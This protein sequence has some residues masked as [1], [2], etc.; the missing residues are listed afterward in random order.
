MSQITVTLYP[1]SLCRFRVVLIQ[2]GYERY[3]SIPLNCDSNT[4]LCITDRLRLERSNTGDFDA[5]A[6][7]AEK[8]LRDGITWNH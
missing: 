6:M 8:I 5:V 3:K 4:A 2:G 7:Q 1:V